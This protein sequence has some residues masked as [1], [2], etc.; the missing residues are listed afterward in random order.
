[1]ADNITLNAGSGGDTV[2]ADEVS[3]VKYQVIKLAAGGDGVAQLGG[4]LHYKTSAAST[5]ATS[6]KASA[7]VVYSITATNTNSSARYLRFYNKA[8]SPTVGT[9]TVVYG[10]AIPGSGGIAVEYALGLPF[11]TGIA[12]SLT[13]G[14][15]DSDTTGVAADEIKLNI[16]YA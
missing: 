11:G 8:S 4:T 9:D 13:T 1:M 12:Y 16:S 5:N 3:G 6:L 7:G 10:I 15:A 2:A 14:A